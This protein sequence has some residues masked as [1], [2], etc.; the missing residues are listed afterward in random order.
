MT[1]NIKMILNLLPKKRRMMI[2]S[3]YDI[4]VRSITLTVFCH[5]LTWSIQIFFK[6]KVPTEITRQH[7]YTGLIHPPDK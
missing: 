4:F 5:F 2:S 7:R 3:R 6:S 1:E